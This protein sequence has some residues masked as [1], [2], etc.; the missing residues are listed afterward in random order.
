LIPPTAPP[1]PIATFPMVA[2]VSPLM[3]TTA[4]ATPTA[5]AASVMPTA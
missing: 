4:T 3:S 2:F 1:D 5:P